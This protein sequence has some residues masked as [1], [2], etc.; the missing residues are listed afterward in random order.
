MEVEVPLLP[1]FPSESYDIIVVFD[2]ET[3][4]TIKVMAK[5]RAMAIQTACYT[6]SK[7]EP[8]KISKITAVAVTKV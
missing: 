7:W 3:E 1:P 2:D 6:M 8:K 5:G 4:E